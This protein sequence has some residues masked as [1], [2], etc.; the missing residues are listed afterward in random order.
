MFCI[1]LHGTP[2]T[3][4]TRTGAASSSSLDNLSSTVA[5]TLAFNAAPMLLSLLSM[6]VQSSPFTIENSSQRTAPTGQM[7]V[8]RGRVDPSPSPACKNSHRAHTSHPWTLLL[9]PA[10]S[11][12]GALYTDKY[13]WTPYIRML[14]HRSKNVFIQCVCVCVCVCLCVCV[15]VC[16]ATM[17]DDGS[18]EHCVQYYTVSRGQFVSASTTP[19]W[20]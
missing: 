5:A 16:V 13:S 11:K 8:K 9:S 2:S 1:L 6:L 18:R 14:Q 3:I 10:A 20:D 15:C 12:T 19:P 4:V 7:A 17:L